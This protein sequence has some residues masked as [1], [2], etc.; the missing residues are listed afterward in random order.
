MVLFWLRDYM[1][2]R[3]GPCRRAILRSA[4]YGIAVVLTAVFIW[5]MALIIGLA[6]FPQW[7]Q[8]PR[9]LLLLVGVHM[10][11]SIPS[12]WVRQTQNYQWMWVTALLPAPVVWLLLLQAILVSEPSL[13]VAAVQFSFFSIA[14]LWAASM[15]VVIFRSRYILV[16]LEDLDFAVLFGS[17]SHGLA[18]CAIPLVLLVAA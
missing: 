11:A 3:M 14:L 18:L 10:A 15:V 12:I 6:N 9:V 1:S 2:L 8:S 5:K 7:L 17:V 16:P 4:A 13:E